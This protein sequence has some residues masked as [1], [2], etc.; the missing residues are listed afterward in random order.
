[1][2]ISKGDPRLQRQLQSQLLYLLKLTK[3]GVVRWKRTADRA[4]TFSTAV[5]GHFVVTVWEDTLRRYLKLANIEGQIQ[6]AASSADSDLVDALY[7]EAKRRAFN[8]EKAI[9]DI[10]PG[11]S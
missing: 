5:K 8:L 10:N 4:E 11:G 3:F 1:M 7:S 6:V 2:Q 9:A